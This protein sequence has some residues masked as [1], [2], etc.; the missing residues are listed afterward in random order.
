MFI[1][2]RTRG[3]VLK[4]ID[5]GEADRIF[6]IYT[7]DFGKIKLLAKAE[8]KI[9]SKL[10][11]GLGI[12]CLSEIEFI[13]GKGHKT[14]TDV[15]LINNFKGLKTDLK[16]LK[17]AYQISEILDDLIKGQETDKQ[18]WQILNETFNKLN[19]LSLEVCHLSLVYYYFLWHFFSVLGYQIELY[20][21][22]L[23]QEKLRP[24][25]NYFNMEKGGLI[26]QKCF[27]KVKSGKEISRETV[28]I[29]RI[30]LK[31]DW[32]TL[33][34]LKVEPVY[35]KNLNIISKEYY[36]HIKP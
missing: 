18:I 4:K 31:K 24:E 35:L 21:C 14:L 28:K 6:T 17:I 1:H 5:R 22:A 32:S 20:K 9:K 19:N 33:S 34:K 16:N 15:I 26:C 8:R 27:K 10:R 2:Y 12:F 29:L 30:I 23:C 7:K 3:F 25:K 11:A 13:Q 36:L